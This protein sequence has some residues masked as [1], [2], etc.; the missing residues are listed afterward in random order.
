MNRDFKDLLCAFN[1]QGVEYLVVG[2]HAWRIGNSESLLSRDYPWLRS[3][4]P[5]DAWLAKLA[6]AIDGGR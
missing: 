4:A 2:A 5:F 3:T 6:P 1:D